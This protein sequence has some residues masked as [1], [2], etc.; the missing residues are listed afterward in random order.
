M[1]KTH[2]TKEIILT[3]DN[4]SGKLVGRVWKNVDKQ[5][6]KMVIF[7]S[8]CQLKILIFFNINVGV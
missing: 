3:S 1:K 6:Q 5:K 8:A 2:K 4:G 7:M